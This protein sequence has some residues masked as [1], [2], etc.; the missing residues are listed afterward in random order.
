[1]NLAVAHMTTPAQ[2]EIENGDAIVVR[3]DAGATLLAVIDALGHGPE[4]AKVADRAVEH[5]ARAPLAAAAAI[6]AGLHDALKGTRGAAASLCVVRDGRIDGCGVGNVEVRIAG[7]AVNVLLTPGILG[8]QVRSL[9]AFEGRLRP[10]DRVVCFSDGISSRLALHEL[11]E[12]TPYAAC[13]LVMQRHRRT[14]DDATV[15]IADVG[16]AS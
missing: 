6:M 12:L 11:H 8:H 13:G 16:S 9:R 5:L 1:M 2:G 10:G 4:A 3:R 14:H 7:G 15:L